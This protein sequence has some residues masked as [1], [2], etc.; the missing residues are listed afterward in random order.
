MI[1]SKG[2]TLAWAAS[3][4]YLFFICLTPFLSPAQASSESDVESF[5]TVIGI[6]LGTTY[7]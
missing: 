2:S 7:S 4:F 5:G 1:R 6:D 3:L